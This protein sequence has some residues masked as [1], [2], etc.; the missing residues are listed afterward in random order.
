MEQQKIIIKKLV[1]IF[2]QEDFWKKPYTVDSFTKTT[3]NFSKALEMANISFTIEPVTRAAMFFKTV[4]TILDF[5]GKNHGGYLYDICSYTNEQNSEDA[6]HLFIRL[7]IKDTPKLG[8]AIVGF[9]FPLYNS[10]FLISILKDRVSN[11]LK[12]VVA[13][14]T[15]EEENIFVDFPAMAAIVPGVLLAK[16]LGISLSR[17]LKYEIPK[18]ANQR[19]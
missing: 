3:A 19:N 12:K 8:D 6:P 15:E 2:G 4:L 5:G 10:K 14:S 13:L 9:D 1:N 7:T 18:I 16:D 11:Q 17:V